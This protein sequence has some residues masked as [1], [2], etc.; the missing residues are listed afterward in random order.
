MLNKFRQNKLGNFILF[1]TA[2]II[3]AALFIGC[4]ASGSSADSTDLSA[5][6]TAGTE[7]SI[8]DPGYSD[9]DLAGTWDEESATKITLKGSSFDVS[10]S[11]AKA[12]GSTLTITDAGVYVLT[13]TLTDGRIMVEAADSD[14]VQ[15]VL[16]EVSLTSSD[17]APIYVKQA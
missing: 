4:Q 16:N 8:I 7:V 9:R 5:G 17:K 3:M 15:I 6:T 10:G 11:G 14:K 2:F 13:G 12:V 1:L